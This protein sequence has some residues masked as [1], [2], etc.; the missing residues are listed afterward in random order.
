MPHARLR[1]AALLVAAAGTL[2]ARAEAQ[3]AAASA[4]AGRSLE[5]RPAQGADQ[6]P[7]FAGQ[8]RAPA[9]PASAPYDVTV[10][11]RGLDKLWAVEPLP[12]GDLLV[13]E[14][15]GRLRIVSAAGAV[16]APVA[17]VPRVDARGQGGLLD[18][19]L[20]PT[21]ARDRTLFWSF[22]EPREGGNA[23]SVARG[24]LSAD[25][26]RLDSVRVILRA[27][28]AYDGGLHFGSRL[29]FGTDGMLYVTLGDRSDTPMRPHAQRLDSHMGKI[30]RVRPDGTAPSDNPFAGRAGALPEIWSLGH[31]NVQAAAMD[32]SGRLW[33]IE[34][35]ARGGDELN[36]VE[37]G[38]NYGWPVAA[39]GLE[40]SGRPITTI[41]LGQASTARE[42]TVQP[43]YYWDPVIAPSG[44]E[45]Y[46]GAAFPAWRGSLFVGNMKDK[47]LTRLDPR[48]RPRHRRGAPA[49]RPRPAHPRRAPGAR[50]R[51]V[52]GDGRRERRAVADQP[53]ATL[54]R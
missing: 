45:F 41:G 1:S 6:S 42:N 18:V 21:F 49:R 46:T 38:R 11:A 51:A 47:N 30:L 7:A 15:A 22:S 20:S 2:S 32:A 48:R 25:R 4:A 13:T 37:R 17:G 9:A 53:A 12:G 14:K 44:A 29:A 52:R 8:T 19:A 3:G 28:P 5:T 33:E 27:R 23:T 31:R 43:V 54:A 50:R 24:V 34:H 40:Y 39:Y 36:L 26:T 16:G 10:V 35:G